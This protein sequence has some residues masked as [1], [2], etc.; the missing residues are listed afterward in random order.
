MDHAP[1]RGSLAALVSR[2]W[3]GARRF[4]LR[5]RFERGK[6]AKVS[7]ASAIAGAAAVSGQISMPSSPDDPWDKAAAANPS[8]RTVAP[9]PTPAA[10]NSSPPPPGPPGGRPPPFHSGY[11]YGGGRGSYLSGGG[12][13]APRAASPTTTSASMTKDAPGGSAGGVGILPSHPISETAHG[14]SSAG[15]RS[16]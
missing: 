15:M 2:R 16:G 6:T 4:L 12:G 11:G 14:S 9:S 3:G 10:P 8:S 5:V 13:G 7:V 1:L